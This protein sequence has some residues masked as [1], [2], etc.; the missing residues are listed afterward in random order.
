MKLCPFDIVH[1]VFSTCSVSPDANLCSIITNLPF[2]SWLLA[3]EYLEF[4]LYLNIPLMLRHW[5][6]VFSCWK[7]FS[8]CLFKRHYCIFMHWEY[9]T[10]IKGHNFSNTSNMFIVTLS[11]DWSV[12]PEVEKADNEHIM[13][14]IQSKDCSWKG[15]QSA[16]LGDQQSL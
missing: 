14:N 9:C 7:T 11:T 16:W 10:H 4:V 8:N 15:T 2:I 12:I 1:C 5:C 13:G 6:L 3:F